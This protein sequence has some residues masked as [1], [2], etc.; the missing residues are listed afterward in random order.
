MVYTIIFS[1]AEGVI[2]FLFILSDHLK[3]NPEMNQAGMFIRLFSTWR[4]LRLS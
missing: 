1:L 3:D 2:F 4:H